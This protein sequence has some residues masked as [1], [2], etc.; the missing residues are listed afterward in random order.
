[1]LS[2]GTHINNTLLFARSLLDRVQGLEFRLFKF[3]TIKL[4]SGQ[5]TDTSHSIPAVSLRNTATAVS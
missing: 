2:V 3:D 5:Q 4:N 1:M